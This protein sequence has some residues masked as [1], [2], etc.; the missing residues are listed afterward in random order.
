MRADSHRPASALT[1]EI[2]ALRSWLFDHALPLWWEVGADRAGGGFH[3]AIDLDGK[4]LAR[5]HRARTITRQAHCYCEAGRFGW[6]GPW[7]EA[8]E[9]ALDYFRRHFIAADHTVVSVVEL[10]GSCRDPRFDL[11]DQGFALLAFAS[12]HRAFGAGAGWQRQAAALRS[13][14]RQTYAHPLGGFLQDRAGRLPQTAN[15][16][17]HLLE[18]ALAWSTLDADPAWRQMADGIVALCLEKMIEPQSGALRELFAADLSSTPGIEGRICEPGHHYEWAFLLDRWARLAQRGTLQ[19]AQRLVAFADSHGVDAR[20]GVVVNAVLLDGSV[21]DPT[22]RL[23]AQAERLRWYVTSGRDADAVISAAK[24]LRRFLGTPIPGLWLDQLDD[25]DVLLIEP[26][27]ATSLYHVM[28]VV[29][30]LPAAVPAANAAPLPARSFKAAPPRVI[31]LVT[32][33]WYFVSHRLPMARAARSAGFEVHVATRVCRHAATI[34]AEGFHLH[35]VSWQRGSLD[36]RDLFRTVR[37][38]RNLYR[39]LKPD[40]AHH[41]ALPATIVGTLAARGLQTVCVNAMT[42]LGTIFV[43]NSARIA[44]ARLALMPALRWLLSR[45]YSTVLVQNPDDRA[46]VQKLGVEPSRIAL[47]AG[48]GVD[49]VALRPQPEPAGQIAVGFLGRLVESKGVRALVEAHALL[50]ARKRDIR[51]VIAGLPDEA[52][53]SSIPAHEIAAWRARHDV[54]YLGFVDDIAVFWASVHIAV[55]PSHR[56]GLPL[57]LLQAAACGKPLIATDVPG[58]RE[59]A[60]SGLNALLVPVDDVEALTQAIERLV[61]DPQLRLR[62]GEASRR[63]VEQEFS[64]ERIG[65]ELVALY[66][67]LL[68][69]AA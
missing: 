12:A 61:L 63:L 14:L 58:C 32:E 24:A 5:P 47:I 57:S 31:Y 49:T 19:A 64:S 33:D 39:K 69:Q 66:R 53:P 34:E 65:G 3:E 26:A 40:L 42:G 7:R 56:E 20:R 18:A 50:C 41:V 4:P 45:S 48:S 52:N 35:P 8:A 16:H 21:H 43:S 54:S 17:M 62:F 30:E 68:D 55:L 36:P 44:A 1:A 38:V 15:P 23:W 13:S 10:D 51:L 6:N 25:K 2:A 59:I 29:A 37:E 27:R 22:A 46:V 60:R 11:Y 28:G 9:H 67:H